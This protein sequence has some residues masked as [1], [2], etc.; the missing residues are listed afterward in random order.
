MRLLTQA[1][2]RAYLAKHGVVSQEKVDDILGGF[3]FSKPVYEQPLYPGDTLFQ[4]VRNPSLHA[5][6]PTTGNWFG[7]SGATTKGLA[8]MDGHSGRRL[9]KYRV[10]AHTTALE[11]TAVKKDTAWDWAGGGPGGATQLYLP[12]TLLGHVECLGGHQR[13]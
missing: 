13:W 7:I 2:A 10:V 3:D 1:D 11:G 12:P 5:P 8:I 4:F 9:Q 6:S